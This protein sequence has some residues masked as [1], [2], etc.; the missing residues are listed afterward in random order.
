MERTVEGMDKAM[1]YA[2]ATQAMEGLKVSEKQEKLILERMSGKITE[3]EFIEK[4][5]RLANG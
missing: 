4:A 1:E 5:R 3:K 2:K